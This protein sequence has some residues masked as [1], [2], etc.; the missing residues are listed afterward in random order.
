MEISVDG[1]KVLASVIPVGLLI[2]AIHTRGLRQ[3]IRV[4]PKRV[5]LYATILVI[6]ASVITVGLC[7]WCANTGV[8]LGGFAAWFA[9]VASVLLGLQT[10][11]TFYE[12]VVISM[13]EE[14]E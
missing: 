14:D 4:V 8:A 6:A 1:A 2:I 7:F 5:A 13:R 3:R 9:V 11:A 10:V 12:F